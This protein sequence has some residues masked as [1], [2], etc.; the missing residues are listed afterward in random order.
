M[1]CVIAHRFSTVIS[2]DIIVVM[3]NGRIVATGTHQ[4]LTETCMLYRN[5]YETQLIVPQEAGKGDD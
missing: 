3:D 5:L 2:A 4:E 1:L